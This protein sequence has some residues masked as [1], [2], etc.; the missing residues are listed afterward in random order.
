MDWILEAADSFGRIFDCLLLVDGRP[1]P[2]EVLDAV[3][4]FMEAP[5]Q[6]IDVMNTEPPVS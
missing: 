4:E 3:A 1:V 5:M 6:D 2:L